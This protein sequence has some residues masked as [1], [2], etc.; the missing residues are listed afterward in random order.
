MREALFTLNGLSFGADT[1]YPIVGS[2]RGL[3]GSPSLRQETILRPQQDGAFGGT[4]FYGTRRITFEGLILNE[5]GG[6][7]ELYDLSSALVAALATKAPALL[8]LEL[9]DGRQ[10]QT[11]VRAVSEVGVSERN[12][13]T[14]ADWQAQ[15]EALD[16]RLYAGGSASTV[17]VGLPDSG[18]TGVEFP[19]ES[20]ITFGSSPLGGIATATNA[21]TIET[22]WTATISGP[23]INPSI[24]HVEQGLTLEF[25]GELEADETLVVD[26]DNHAVLLNGSTNR[27]SWLVA[28]AWFLLDPGANT[29]RFNATSGTG[30]LSLEWRSAW[31]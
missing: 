23:I 25:I 24:E 27:Y 9:D 12:V 5:A 15:L 16:P 6:W 19:M 20:P 31:L 3:P 2:I 14:V 21:G 28:P 17:E 26:G 13:S 10:L 30:T 7:G 22:P 11:L 4:G 18:G 1:D 29:I 8:E